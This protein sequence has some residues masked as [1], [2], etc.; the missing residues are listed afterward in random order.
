MASGFFLLLLICW[1]LLPRP[2]LLEDVS[3]SQEIVDRHH[4][5]LKITLS[6]DDKY[7]IRV[8]LSEISPEMIRA[9]LRQ[10]DRFF[11]Y[12]CGVN[13]IST[14]RAAFH[15]ASTS[16]IHPGAS[17]LSMQVARLRFHLQTR[18]LLGKLRQMVLALELERHYSK[19]QLLEAYFNLAPYGGNLEGIGAAA[20]ILLG[21]SPSQISLP[22]AAA[23]S[24]IPQSP[25]RRSLLH[26]VCPE[27][28]TLAQN[29]LLEH[30]QADPSV[31]GFRAKKVG[32]LPHEAPHLCNELLAKNPQEAIITTTLDLP[33][34]HLLEDRI[35]SYLKSLQS[36]DV[37][38]A[39]ALLVDSSTMEVL[40]QVGS[41]DFHDR[42]IQGE[43]DGTHCK[44]SPG[45]TLKPFVYA[46]AMQ[47]GLIH[48]LTML[49]DA[50]QSFGEYN[51]ENFDRDFVGPISAED[52]LVRSRNIPAIDLASRLT[53]P[54][55][56][57]FLETAGVRFPK[58]KSYYGLTLPLGGAEVTMHEL[59]RLYCL[60][61]NGGRFRALQTT[62]PS[63][64]E[65]G[66]YLLSPEVSFLTLHMLE[67]NPPLFSIGQQE[68]AVAWKTGTSNGFHDAWSVGVFD[69]MVLVV[70][71]GN[72]DGRSNHSLVGRTCAGPLF[73]QIIDSLQSRG[74]INLTPRQPPRNANLKLV[75][76][77]AVSGGLATASCK[78][79]VRGWFIPGVSPI[80]SCDI[81]RTVL[82]D[83]ETGLRVLSED[84][85][86]QTDHEIY[87]FWPSDLLDLFKRAGLPRKIPPPFLPGED[88]EHT[89]R[90][91]TP[92]V[93]TSPSTDTK[94]EISA[95]SG[96]QQYLPL[97]ARTDAD[98]HAVYWFIDKEFLGRSLPSLPIEW[99]MK[100]GSH[101][102][103]IL[104][105]LGRSSSRIFTVETASQLEERY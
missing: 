102:A 53:K 83:E 56:Y 98:T 100:S 41:A 66:Q 89:S 91:G 5:P 11:F 105:D 101:T 85:H 47:Q 72:F 50:P 27:S 23:L 12:H 28:L 75:D 96:T 49:K 48:P 20:Q 86:H 16:G 25:T 59:A 55:L 22:E 3:F 40:A 6:R 95:H 73:F 69:K 19:Q 14:L 70:W 29:R 99:K 24:V 7:R 71:L 37:K 30:L 32:L 10:E 57:N 17:T 64:Q 63:T 77:C 79:R 36:L 90:N 60:L 15:A 21:K 54:D 76:F 46:I 2:P 78:Q 9:T 74:L 26:G 80:S 45:S 34:Q 33:L 18:T 8:L 35:K 92:P 13:P 82:I 62:L 38:N 88:P 44:R 84:G 67:K 52:A 87:E 93:I 51:P 42:S 94:Y 97:S 31:M 81:H 65:S 39:S 1:L 68:N 43:I 61:E 103:T 104:D 4:Q 58:E